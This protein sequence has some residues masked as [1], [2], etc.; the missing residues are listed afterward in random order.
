MHKGSAG[1]R[2]G[3]MVVPHIRAPL[4]ILLTLGNNP[5]TGV[6]LCHV[7]TRDTP[8]T[9]HKRLKIRR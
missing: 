1:Y 5:L 2:G 9:I 3:R 7:N 8:H 6:D 4:A